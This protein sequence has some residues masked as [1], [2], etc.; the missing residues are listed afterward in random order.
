M[1]VAIT[2]A[3]GFIGSYM[4]GGMAREGHTVRVLARKGRESAV[5][6]PPGGRCEVHIGDLTDAASLSGFLDDCDLLLHLASAHEH[7]GQEEMQLVNIRGTEHLVA[8]AKRRAPK[9]PA[10]SKAH[11]S[12][13]RRGR[14]CARAIWDR[15]LQRRRSF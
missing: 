1:R 11:N 7:L 14:D 9:H 3:T 15:R 5:A 12:A 6:H 8:E 2:G 10:R 4:I 13:R